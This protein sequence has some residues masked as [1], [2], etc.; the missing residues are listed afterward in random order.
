MNE[1]HVT[2]IKAYDS[3]LEVINR[4]AGG[5]SNYTYLVKNTTNSEQ[6]VFRIKGENGE[7][8]VNYNQEQK[9]LKTISNLG[10][11]SDTV[12][13]D[14]SIGRK[15]AKYIPGEM[16]TTNVDYK[17]IAD[18]LKTLH[19]SQLEFAN[20][21][22]PLNK[23]TSFEKYHNKKQDL[24]FS[25]KTHF[26]VIYHEHLEKNKLVPCHNDSQIANFILADD[27]KYYLLDWEFSGNND[28]YYDIASFGNND[29]DDAIKLLKAYITKPT[30]SDLYYVYAWRMFQC[31]QWYN[32]AQA[33]HELGMSEKLN[34]PF[35]QVSD[36]YL[37][38]A[39]DL[40]ASLLEINL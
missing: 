8:F 25:L 2:E 22:D 18:T 34:I 3:N 29:F 36:M 20:N 19:D 35:D 21:Y 12:Y 17:L 40:Y 16:I 6:F 1:K 7:L 39:N 27:G 23:L 24:Y 38:K 11:N 28:L 5:M 10:I 31:L 37:K 33:K 4:F 32:V 15:I 26:E 30:N 14:P 13:V 9:N